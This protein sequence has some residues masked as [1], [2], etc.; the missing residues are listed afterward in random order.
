MLGHL[1][2]AFKKTGGTLTVFNE[3]TKELNSRLD[4]R[5]K[6]ENGAFGTATDVLCYCVGMGWVSEEQAEEYGAD[7]STILEG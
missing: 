1:K 7:V 4:S 5:T 6:V 3:Q 2:K